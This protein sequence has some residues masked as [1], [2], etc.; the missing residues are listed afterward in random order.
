MFALAAQQRTARTLLGAAAAQLRR[1]S[2]AAAASALPDCITNAVT[3]DA[4][5]ALKRHGYAVVDGV[6]GAPLA[7]ELRKE[8]VALKA[9]GCM[10]VN[11]THLVR[12]GETVRLEKRSIYEAEA[13]ALQPQG[14]ALAP[15]LSALSRDRTL[16]TLLTIFMETS[17]ADA[18]HY[19]SL[20]LQLNEGG[21]ACFPL[22]HDTDA[23]LD[24]RRLTALFYLNPD[25]R[26]EHGGQLVLYPFPG[27]HVVI[28]PRNDRLV[29]FSAPDMLHR[30][31]PSSAERVC[32]TM[33][34]FARDEMRKKV[35]ATV[36]YTPAPATLAALLH[37]SV[38]KHAA[39]A[40]YAAEWERSIVEAH[41]DTPAR[42][43]AVDTLRKEV[44]TIERV[45]EQ[46]FSGARQL[47]TELRVQHA[48][49][50]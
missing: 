27:K 34:L 2:S 25:W 21:A 18:L 30:V 8:I 6:F 28:E 11:A 43:A 22:H 23:T 4:V 15:R 49:D 33:W 35:P 50:A 31:L 44:A 17:R 26:A 48:A 14:A 3:G 29:L 19:Q 10:R 37:P 32:F 9:A 1:H 24:T 39:K 40:V 38:A 12:D 13:H 45:L 7:G 20:K 16:L 41:P 36:E 47:L 5:A 42:A 46:R